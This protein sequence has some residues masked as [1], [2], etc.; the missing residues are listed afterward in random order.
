MA[1]GGTNKRPFYHLIVTD[2]RNARDGR[3]IE[4]VGYFNPIASGKEIRL[5]VDEDRVNYWL[6]K[7]AQPSERVAFLLTQPKTTP[8]SQQS[9]ATQAT[10]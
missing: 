7:G 10:E 6:S 2:K 4:R 1:R 3:N 9:A 8:N 5:F